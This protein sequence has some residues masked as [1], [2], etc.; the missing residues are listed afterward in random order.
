M[1]ELTLI[2]AAVFAQGD[3]TGVEP[4]RETACFFMIGT[5]DEDAEPAR[6]DD[7]SILNPP[8]DK[9]KFVVE[10]EE[11]VVLSSVICRR[12]RPE[13]SVNDFR[14]VTEGYQFYVVSGEPGSDSE[15]IIVL[16]Q[17][18]VGHRVR[19]ITGKLTKQ[20]KAALIPVI[21]ELNNRQF[22]RKP[23]SKRE[24]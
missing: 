1:K 22:G 19:I 18:K 11:G 15:V 9:P 6:I 8:A 7:L 13:I 3:K 14:V 16:E 23:G 4:L 20:E 12:S 21:D 17:T 5:S 10:V 24:A 2:L